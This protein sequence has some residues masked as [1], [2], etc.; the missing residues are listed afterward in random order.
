MDPR[1]QETTVEI[2]AGQ[3]IKKQRKSESKQRSREREKNKNKLQKEEIVP[4]LVE[5]EV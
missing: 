2:R 5:E 3:G 4:S 1:N